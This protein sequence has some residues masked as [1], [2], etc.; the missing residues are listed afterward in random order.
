MPDTLLIKDSRN[1]KEYT[2]PITNDTIKATD[3]RQ[4]Y[5]FTRAYV[6]ERIRLKE[7]PHATYMRSKRFV[8]RRVNEAASPLYAEGGVPKIVAVTSGIYQPNPI[9]FIQ[10]RFNG[11]P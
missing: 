7:W 10:S 3:L 1:G 4:I 6:L 11:A 9:L 8:D 2:V 5:E